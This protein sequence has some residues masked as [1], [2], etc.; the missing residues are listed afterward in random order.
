MKIVILSIGTFGDVYPYAAL[1]EGLQKSGYLVTLA[2]HEPYRKFVSEKELDY[3][4]LCGDPVQ[5]DK[6]RKLAELVESSH[7]FIGW[8]SKLKELA[9]KL[10][11]EIFSSCL[12]A[13]NGADAIIYSPLA[14]IGCSIAEKAKVPGICA[15]LQPFLKTRSFPSPWLSGLINTGFAN[16]LSHS[17]VM[18]VYWQFNK[19]YVNHF[20]RNVLDLPEFGRFGPFGSSE[21]NN[22]LFLFGLSKH[23]LPKP[24]DWPSN[25][26]VTG[27]WRFD[28]DRNY[29]PDK[30]LLGFLNEGEKPVYLGFGSMPNDDNENLIEIAH[31]AFRKA[32]A[33]GI[34]Q[35]KTDGG[36][37]KI[38][39]HLFNASWSD[40]DWLFENSSIVICHGGISTLATALN[41]GTPV[42]IIPHAWDQGFWGNL[43][44]NAGFGIS[45]CSRKKL[46]SDVLAQAI[47]KIK[48]NSQFSS[49]TLELAQK[50]R[51]ED[52]VGESVRLIKR[53]VETVLC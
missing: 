52:G 15:S 45:P 9:D 7:N 30:E 28:R 32:G 50:I 48:N 39:P 16:K 6:D 22:Q 14:W 24:E 37:D 46:T 5:W 10:I 20:R 36:Y 33:R 44:E 31:S 34:V 21:F 25:A 47:V 35:I 42:I 4:P 3:A 26:H 13:C 19:P 17:L 27:F 38:S 29:N 1:A 2:T 12:D 11:P 49:R 23:L 40:H 51:A 41:S 53:H 8:M 18:Q 43:V